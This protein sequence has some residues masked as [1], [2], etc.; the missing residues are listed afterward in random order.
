VW[1]ITGSKWTCYIVEWSDC[2]QTRPFE[3]SS[4]F[5]CQWLYRSVRSTQDTKIFLVVRHGDKSVFN[6]WSVTQEVRERDVY[7]DISSEETS[8]HLP[9][10]LNT[11]TI[12]HHC[13]LAASI[14]AVE[15]VKYVYIKVPAFIY[16]ISIVICL[17]N[18]TTQFILDKSDSL[19]INN[20]TTE[21]CP[22]LSVQ[23]CQRW[24]TAATN[25]LR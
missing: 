7:G 13:M 25:T 20:S 6:Q 17:F 22:N 11:R 1:L 9:W 24:W 10:D 2:R 3:R 4:R 12:L 15:T 18:K 19:L 14:L 8:Q 16:N 23:F 21:H 5:C